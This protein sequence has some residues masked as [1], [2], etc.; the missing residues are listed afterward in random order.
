[1]ST[2]FTKAGNLQGEFTEC[3]STL[4][5]FFTVTTLKEDFKGPFLFHTQEVWITEMGTLKLICKVLSKV[6]IFFFS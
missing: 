1:M 2:I 5:F 6:L 3:L 4:Q